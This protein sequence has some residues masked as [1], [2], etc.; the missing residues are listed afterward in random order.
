MAAFHPFETS[1]GS[2]GHSLGPARIEALQCAFN[3]SG[4]GSVAYHPYPPHAIAREDPHLLQMRYVQD[5]GAVL[6]NDRDSRL[7]GFLWF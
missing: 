3:P 7:H 4:Q 6:E 2:L 1:A 5:E